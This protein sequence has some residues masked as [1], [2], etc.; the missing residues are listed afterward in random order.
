MTGWKSV[1]LAIYLLGI[2]A[3]AHTQNNDLEHRADSLQTYVIGLSTQG[4][5]D[6]A[7]LLIEHVVQMRKQTGNQQELL[8]AYLDK[9]EILRS[10]ADLE[11]AI[12]L[13]EYC[14]T[15]FAALEKIYLQADL[16]NRKAAVLFEMKD[17][18]GA[19][20]AVKKSQQL[21]KEMGRRALRFSNYNIEGAIYR[22]Q[23]NQQQAIAV[24]RN[25]AAWAK[26]IGNI[27]ELC[28]GYYNLAQTYYNQNMPDSAL[29]YANGFL[30]VDFSG[31]SRPVIEHVYNLIAES[32]EKQGRYD[33]AYYYLDTTHSLRKESMDKILKARVGESRMQ[34]DLEI[35]K[36]NNE[37]LQTQ[38]EHQKTQAYLLLLGVLLLLV[39]LAWFFFQRNQ[40]KKI[41]HKQRELNQ[42][43]QSS[44]AFKNKLIGI[45]AHDIRNPMNG[46]TGVIEL[47]NRDMVEPHEFKQLML[48]LE[49]AVKNVNLLV[50]NLVNWVKSQGGDFTVNRSTFSLKEMV[51][52]VAEQAKSLMDNKALTLQLQLH[53]APETFTTDENMLSLILRNLLS[54]AI[55]FSHKGQKIHLE[56]RDGGNMH[57]IT[58]KDEGVG[59]SE[60]KI[61]DI[62]ADKSKSSSGTQS[63]K[64]T[65]LGLAL[66]REMLAELGGKMHITSSPGQGTSINVHWP[67]E[68]ES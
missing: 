61:K 39:L 25:S 49:G 23:H 21:A 9:I 41:H 66:C 26:E 2:C 65:G 34:S 27:D 33:L 57:C 6:S 14:E 42:E 13:V 22:E 67:K 24:L 55:K 12:E 11:R 45:V 53:E 31:Q 60:E 20:K 56:Y 46:V 18:D 38:N 37:V 3:I 51:A 17:M 19:L 28:L 29:Y 5:K 58:V 68:S 36:L 32:Y 44:L 48:K 8:R 59:M 63:E 35:Q 62:L 1:A 4:K 47:F 15:H 30:E 43:L 64:G 50:E 10:I 54:N 7:L 16:Q 40:L 52:E